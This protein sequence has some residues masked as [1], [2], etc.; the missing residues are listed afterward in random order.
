MGQWHQ[1]LL[2]RA[3]GFVQRSLRLL[4]LVGSE[5]D[6]ERAD[7]GDRDHGGAGMRLLGTAP[8]L[9]VE[10]ERLVA[11]D[12]ADR[13]AP[14]RDGVGVVLPRQ[15]HRESLFSRQWQRR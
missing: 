1:D 2:L 3:P 8:R 4:E 15:A 10:R 13:I 7:D 11:D 12:P 9:V 6:H 14:C 5:L